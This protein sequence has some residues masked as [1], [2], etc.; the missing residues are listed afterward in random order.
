[1]GHL[2]LNFVFC[3]LLLSTIAVGQYVVT[4]SV[5]TCLPSLGSM[6]FINT[7]GPEPSGLPA[8]SGLMPN[9]PCVISPLCWQWVHLI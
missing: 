4:V 8:G 5:G 2:N 3:S 9:K 7:V 1:M 6:S